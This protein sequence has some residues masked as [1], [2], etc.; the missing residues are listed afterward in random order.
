MD[1]ETTLLVGGT[2]QIDLV[3][4][5]PSL[6]LLA[7]PFACVLLYSMVSRWALRLCPFFFIFF[8]SFLQIGYFYSSTIMFGDILSIIYLF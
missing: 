6:R 8:V 1:K 7:L 5:L 3:S 4:A 2:P